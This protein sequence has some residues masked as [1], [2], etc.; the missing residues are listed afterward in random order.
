M[1]GWAFRVRGSG[2]KIH[3]KGSLLERTEI[4]WRLLLKVPWHPLT[5]DARF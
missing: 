4:G 5:K 3:V 2:C 1:L